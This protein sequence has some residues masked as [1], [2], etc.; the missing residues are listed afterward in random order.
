MILG[1]YWE[2]FA[3]PYRWFYV[4][5]C[6]FPRDRTRV[7]FV[8]AVQNNTRSISMARNGMREWGIRVSNGGSG[9]YVR[10][11]EKRPA[12]SEEWG[13]TTTATR[14]R[15][16]GRVWERGEGAKEKGRRYAYPDDYKRRPVLSVRVDGTVAVQLILAAFQ[17]IGYP[18]PEP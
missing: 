4:L 8:Y 9:A 5:D 16:R 7:S 1:Y 17:K 13:A 12:R 6:Q 18:P 3:I 11:K 2:F 14:A 15:A 10:I